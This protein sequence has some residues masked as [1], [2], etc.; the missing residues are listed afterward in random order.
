ME[1][2]CRIVADAHEVPSGIPEWLSSLG[3]AVLVER[4]AVGDYDIGSRVIVERKSVADLHESLRRGR[5]WPQL[6]RLRSTASVPCLLVE[7]SHLGGPVSGASIRAALLAVS[8]LGILIVRSTSRR[9][10]GEWL[11][12]LARR[13]MRPPVHRLRPA[14]AQ[15]A[16]PVGADAP[17]AMLAAVPGISAGTARALLSTFGS[18]V[19]V[20]AASDGELRRVHGMGPKRI[21]A[22]RRTAF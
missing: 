19:N 12:S 1:P 11:V 8:D 9:D 4:L 21:H 14:Y 16:Q 10:T 13:S 2:V 17:Q 3:A 18:V 7:G 20:L 5:L 15:R 22:L 6:G